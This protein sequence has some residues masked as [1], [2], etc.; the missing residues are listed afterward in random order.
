MEKGNNPGV[1][2]D[3]TAAKGR[4]SPQMR[5]MRCGTSDFDS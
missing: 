1:R 5:V 4:R 2:K 3:D